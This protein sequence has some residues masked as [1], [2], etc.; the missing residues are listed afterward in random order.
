MNIIEELA[1]QIADANRRYHALGTPLLSDAEY[2]ALVDKLQELAPEHPVLQ[3]VGNRPAVDGVLHTTPMLSLQKAYTEEE[4]RAW[5]A[6][7]PPGQFFWDMKYDGLAVE[8]R[9]DAQGTFWQAVTRG[10]GHVGQDI[11]HVVQQM[12]NVPAGQPLSALR[13]ELCVLLSTFAKKGGKHPRNVAAGIVAAKEHEVYTPAD[14]VFLAH[15]CGDHMDPDLLHCAL[16]TSAAGCLLPVDGIVIFHERWQELG[17]TS[18]HPKGAIA[19]KFPDQPAEATISHVD[20]QVSGTGILTPVAV[21]KTPV[22]LSGASVSQ[23]TLHNLS[24]VQSLGVQA[25]C[26]VR[27]VRRGGVIPHIE[28][29]TDPGPGGVS[30]GP[31]STCPMCAERTRIE[32]RPGSQVV[33]CTNLQCPAAAA[34]RLE[35]WC[36]AVGA[37]G[38]GPAICD[39]LVAQGAT[40]ILQLYQ[41]VTAPAFATSTGRRN[42]ADALRTSRVIATDKLLFGLG[43]PGLGESLSRQVARTVTLEQ[44]FDASAEELAEA[45]PG[46]GVP[47]AQKVLQALRLRMT[48]VATLIAHAYVDYVDVVQPVRQGALS[49]EVVCFTGEL[50]IDRLTAAGLAE[51]AGAVVASGVTKK[52]TLLIAADDTPSTKYKKAQQMSVR[53]VDGPGF[54]QLVGYQ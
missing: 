24:T 35:R 51:S 46:L 52:T 34:R 36:K 41:L 28:A 42:L 14:L 25:G 22:L 16:R 2:D 43:L 45:V 49:G 54:L 50:T 29:V 40:D 31:P 3:Q 15:A 26:K 1:E 48:E 18:H 19:F 21:F 44:L 5:M 9:F 12:S 11:T 20:W 8:L 37:D 39:G 6:T 32:D 33:V 47:T 30:A 7:M 4:V 27:V 17:F 13:G 38:F 23:A 53:I 10:D